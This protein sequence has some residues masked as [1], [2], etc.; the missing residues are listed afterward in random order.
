MN[1]LIEVSKVTKKLLSRKITKN[2]KKYSSQAGKAK[3]QSLLSVHILGKFW[4]P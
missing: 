4:L 2:M 3:S 1:F